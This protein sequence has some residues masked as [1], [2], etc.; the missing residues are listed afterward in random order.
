MMTDESTTVQVDQG[1]GRKKQAR[2]N[3]FKLLLSK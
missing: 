3:Q 2:E 1:F